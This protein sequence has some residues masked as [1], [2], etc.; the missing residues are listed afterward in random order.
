[1]SRTVRS[2]SEYQ[3]SK[4]RVDLQPGNTRGCETGTRFA[5]QQRQCGRAKNRRGR[6]FRVGALVAGDNEIV[7]LQSRI[8]TVVDAADLED[9]YNT[10]RHLLNIACTRAREHLLATR[11]KPISEFLDDL[12]M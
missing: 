5:E 2:A 12:Q 10:E 6:E 8:Q 3:H 9:V 11:V 4:K 7:P 1:M